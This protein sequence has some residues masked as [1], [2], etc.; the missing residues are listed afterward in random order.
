M[1]TLLQQRDLARQRRREQ[2]YEE[3]RRRLKEALA[4]LLPG[5]PVIV[6]GSLTRRGAF[7]DA[8]DVDL[9]LEH[10]PAG[11]SSGQLMSELTERMGRPVD[12]ILLDRCRWR[13]QIRRDGEMWTC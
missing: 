13:D 8:S 3:T 10:E 2:V 7:H 1:T 11:I 4:E 6:F 5:Q 12:V 9:A